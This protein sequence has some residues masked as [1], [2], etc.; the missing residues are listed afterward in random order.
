MGE[1]GTG[2]HS[3]TLCQARAVADAD[4]ALAKRG[5]RMSSTW[6]ERTGDPG[7]D[8]ALA[9][10]VSGQAARQQFARP[11]SRGI[12]L[13]GSATG[14]GVK[15]VRNHLYIMVVRRTLCTCPLL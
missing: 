15:G 4:P 13:V 6:P 5:S 12:S 8:L 3:C 7:N 9:L 14:H 11:E 10:S 2:D 1:Q